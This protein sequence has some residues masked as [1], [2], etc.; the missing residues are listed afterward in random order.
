[1]HI[2]HKSSIHPNLTIECR[3]CTLHI[4]IQLVSRGGGATTPVLYAASAVCVC[5]LYGWV[6]S[7]YCIPIIFHCPKNNLALISRKMADFS[8]SL[9]LCVVCDMLNFWYML[10]PSHMCF[11]YAFHIIHILVPFFHTVSIS[12]TYHVTHSLTRHIVSYFSIRLHD[13]KL[14]TSLVTP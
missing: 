5:V 4:T 10:F 12:A 6:L 14:F 7:V 8:P 3:H 2:L 9:L 11:T 13:Y 1:M